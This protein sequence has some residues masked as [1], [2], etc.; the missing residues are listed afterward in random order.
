[1]KPLTLIVAMRPDGIIAVNGNIPWHIPEDLKRFKALTMGHAIVMGRKTFE[2]IGRPLPNRK[3]IVV[4]RRALDIPV[5]E[6]V[7]GINYQTTF[8]HALAHAYVID[9]LPFVIGGGEIYRQALPLATRLEITYVAQGNAG[10]EAIEV[11]RSVTSVTY[12]PVSNLNFWAW[13]C[14]SAVAAETKNVEFLTYERRESE[15]L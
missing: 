7:A 11:G 13:R 6:A 4:T 9:P 1:M 2:S 3:N 8:G 15:H 5:G 14:V 10:I 12:F